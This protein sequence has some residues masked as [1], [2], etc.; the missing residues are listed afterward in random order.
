MTYILSSAYESDYLA[1]YKNVEKM[2]LTVAWV[3]VFQWNTNCSTIIKLLFSQKLKAN[4][5]TRFLK[6]ANLTLKI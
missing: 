6:V 3:H 2:S 5:D 4:D 1:N